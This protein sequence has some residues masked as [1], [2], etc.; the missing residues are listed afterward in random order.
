MALPVWFRP[1][2]RRDL[3]DLPRHVQVRIIEHLE[4][5]AADPTAPGPQ[6]LRGPWRRFSKL[7]VG[8]YRVI[9][10]IEKDRLHVAAL[11]HR[12]SIYEKL[13]RSTPEFE[14]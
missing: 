11:G 10:R 7:R 8:D 2:A 5:L 13:D 14:Q 1:Q 6:R 3:R 9:L 4:R 12:S